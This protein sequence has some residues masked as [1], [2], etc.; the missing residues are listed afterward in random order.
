MCNDKPCKQAIDIGSINVIKEMLS[1]DRSSGS[2]GLFI[3]QHVRS[4]YRYFLFYLVI[5]Y[6]KATLQL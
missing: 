5:P 4:T 2:V 1:N 6:C 3:I